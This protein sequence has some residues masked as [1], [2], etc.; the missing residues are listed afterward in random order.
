MVRCEGGIDR[1]EEDLTAM[2]SPEYC[3]AVRDA[4]AL[5]RRMETRMA[6]RREVQTQVQQQAQKEG[7]IDWLG[8]WYLF[9]LAAW[10]RTYVT[11]A[12]LCRALP[13]PPP[14]ASFT[15]PNTTI[16]SPRPPRL[17]L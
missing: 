2:E 16:A 6:A 17:R 5:G 10:A 13:P 8:R 12:D 15:V 14:P 9:H 11:R 4:F 1:G 3:R 7:A